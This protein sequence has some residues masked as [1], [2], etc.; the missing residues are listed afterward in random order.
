MAVMALKLLTFFSLNVSLTGSHLIRSSGDTSLENTS[1]YLHSISFFK[2]SIAELRSVILLCLISVLF[3][4]VRFR[5][6]IVVAGMAMREVE[7]S[8]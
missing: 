4:D 5:C 7:Y 1:E 2:E 6:L 3:S 8:T